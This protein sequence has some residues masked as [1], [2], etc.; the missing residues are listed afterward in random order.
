MANARCDEEYR[1][2]DKEAK[3]V[4]DKTTCWLEQLTQNAQQ[5]A[6]R[7]DSKNLYRIV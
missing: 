4:A 1:Q 5:A 3:N 6:D 2:L 7:N